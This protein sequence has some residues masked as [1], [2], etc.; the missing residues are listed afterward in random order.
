[1]NS[2]SKKIARCWC[3]LHQSLQFLQACRLSLLLKYWAQEVIV[4]TRCYHMKV[5]LYLVVLVA[6]QPIIERQNVIQHSPFLYLTTKNIL[7]TINNIKTVKIPCHYYTVSHHHDDG[8]YKHQ[9]YTAPHTQHHDPQLSTEY[10]NTEY[11]MKAPT[12]R[13]NHLMKLLRRYTLLGQTVS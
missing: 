11:T 2:L 4:T 5:L 7:I 12:C 8:T 6:Q 9:S 3:H 10:T 13:F 1:M